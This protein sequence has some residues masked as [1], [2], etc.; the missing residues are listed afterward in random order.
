MDVSNQSAT[1]DAELPEV[2]DRGPRAR[3]YR[4]MLDTASR[5]MQQGEVPSVT[6]VAEAAQVSRATAYRYFPTQAALVTAVVDEALGP[7]LDWRSESDDAEERLVDL[8][9]TAL[10]RIAAYE[11]TFRA[12]LRL[13]LEAGNDAPQND[14]AA[15]RFRRGHRV[16][17]LTAAIAPLR[18]EL[19]KEAHDRL[20]QA[21]SLVFGVEAFVVL[22]DIWGGDDARV[23]DTA[24]WM[25][26]AL[27]GAARAQAEARP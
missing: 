8:F 25:A 20:A 11:A 24:V 26:R 4:L 5:L 21:L 16:E 10:P 17:L 13:S 7:I 1:L 12:A 14:E 6:A 19:G 23:R 15:G 22:K 18:A 2:P 9:E 3:T 27:L